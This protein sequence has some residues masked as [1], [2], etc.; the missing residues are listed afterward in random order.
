[1]DKALHYTVYYRCTRGHGRSINTSDVRGCLES[2]QVAARQSVGKYTVDIINDAARDQGVKLIN[3]T[4]TNNPEILEYIHEKTHAYFGFNFNVT[5]I[6]LSTYTYECT[7]PNCFKCG[8]LDT[9]L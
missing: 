4:Q 6:Y 1:M 8:N 7:M 5:R 2:T 3:F 9:L